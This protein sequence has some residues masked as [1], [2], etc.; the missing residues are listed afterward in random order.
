[1]VIEVRIAA[2]G[3]EQKLGKS[4]REPPGVLEMF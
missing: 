2:A 4:R 3:E 1:M